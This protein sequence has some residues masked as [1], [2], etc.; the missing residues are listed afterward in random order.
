MA[1]KHLALKMEVTDLSLLMGCVHLRTVSYDS[2]ISLRIANLKKRI[3][4]GFGLF[5]GK[6]ERITNSNSESTSELCY[7]VLD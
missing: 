6:F 3:A 5:L 7:S 4:I 1:S 2:L